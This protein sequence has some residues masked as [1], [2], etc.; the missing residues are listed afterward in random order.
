[1]ATY[2]WVGGSGTWD[3]T[4]TTYWA[5]S[6]GGAGSAGVPT[7][8]D[9]VIFDAS[10]NI[11]VGA[12]TVT[13]AG[14]AAAPAV[15]LDFST[16]GAGGALD[17]AMTLAFGTLGYLDCYGSL[18]FPA[19]NFS[20]SVGAT[21]TMLRFLSTT[22]GRTVTTNGVTLSNVPTAFNGVG[23]GWTLGSAFTS[24]TT[25]TLNA[26]TL[27]TGNYNITCGNFVIGGA[28]VRTLNLGSSTIA[29]SVGFSI[30]GSNL[31][32]NA[33]TSTI[34]LSNASPTFAGNGNTFYN[35]NFTSTAIG[36]IA[37]T[38]ANTFNNLSFTARAAAGI[39]SV[40]FDSAATNTVNGTLTLG[41]GTTGVARL[42]L[43]GSVVGSPATLSVATLTAITDIDFR[44]I[45]AAGASSPWSGTRIGNCLGNTSISFVGAR[46]VYWNSALSAN[47]NA[48]VWST[49]SGIIGGTTAAFPLAQ[50]S[51]VIDNA[52][53]TLGNTI[54]LNANYNIPP[55]SFATRSNA[56]T[57]ATGTTTP[58]FYGDYTLS[59]AITLTGTGVFTFA[60]QGGT[61]TVTPA[62]KTFT[63]PVTVNAANGTVRINGDLTLGS[64]LTTTLTQGT[65]D[66]TNNGAGNYLL[67][68]GLFSSSG[69][70]TRAVTFGTS[71]ITLTGNAATIWTTA[72]ATNFSVSGTPVVN[73]TYSGAT[74]T[75]TLSFGALSEAN[76][77]S[78]NV[79][80]GTDI[81]ALTA[82]G[83][84]KN[85]IFTGFAGTLTNTAMTIYGNLLLVSGMTLTAGANA[86]T[87]AGTSG[88]QQITTALKTLDFPL[89]F[90]GIG[91]T[92]AFQD[93]LT[94][95]ATRAFTVTNG[96]VQLKAS[97]T[98]TVGSFV[99][100]GT[101]QKFLQSTSAGTQATLS[102][103]SGVVNT[104]YLTIQD[105][106]ANGGATWNSFYSNGNLDNGNNTNWIFGET[107]AYGAEYEYRLRSFT[108]PR[109][110]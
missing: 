97:A 26:G 87:F 79:S 16:G 15:C 107:P 104:S 72:T 20:I 32:L 73:A 109:R 59:S 50:D 54:T 63:Q 58:N 28:S 103:A 64:T 30:T 19:A 3:A 110:F 34:N 24:T 55:L 9:S 4:T 96:T 83:G 38:G 49:T 77:I 6:S 53:L 95:G 40:T 81:V 51:I 48:A 2:Y 74:G 99:T 90:N 70:L 8:A 91:G 10:S 43:R 80:A 100:S 18:T 45:T 11:G 75:R 66:L 22:T 5:T 84:F 92:F 31:T 27:D 68:T 14:T 17:G 13:V 98:S 94:Q 65:L 7:S 21:T 85:L 61:A 105:I 37:I 88:T 62:G 71:N 93:A 106:F 102:K 101:N 69:A 108:E 44:D 36:S 35:V 57:F 56:A 39:G 78:L 46:T 86:T 29:P 52:G 60:K 89:T 33:G 47:W 25:L 1:M 76:S 12:F 23:G 42:W 82:T 67:N 41:S